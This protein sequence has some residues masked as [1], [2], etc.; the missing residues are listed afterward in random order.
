MNMRGFSFLA[1]RK[2]AAVA[3][4]I[5]LVAAIAAY[6]WHGRSGMIASPASE[7]LSEGV[8]WG[9]PAS[10]TAEA[11]KAASSLA[12]ASERYRDAELG[13][14]FSYP[15]G[16]KASVVRESAVIDGP[17]DWDANISPGNK[18]LLVQDISKNIGI[19]ISTMPF[20]ELLNTLTEDRIR[21]DLG[22]P[23][24]KYSII[25]IGKDQDI[26]AVTFVSGD[27]VLSREVWFIKAGTLFQAVSYQSSEPLMVAILKTLEI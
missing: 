25:K 22:I 9:N 24:A 20:E 21:G 18:A 27:K 11:E 23:I 1:G 17:E 4:L 6:A 12:E 14:S 3:L 7:Q 2:K 5:V 13:I 10:A 26:E 8:E 16:L 15:K 19:Q